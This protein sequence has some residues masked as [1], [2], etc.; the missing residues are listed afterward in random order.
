MICHPHYYVICKILMK[1]S[2][3]ASLNVLAMGPHL[4]KKRNPKNGVLYVKGINAALSG[5]YVSE[6]VIMC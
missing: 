5:V 3:L 2:I 6:N 4:K 1:I